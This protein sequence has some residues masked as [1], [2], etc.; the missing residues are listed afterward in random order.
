[1]MSLQDG[2]EAQVSDKDQTIFLDGRTELLGS[3]Q[4]WKSFAG[5]RDLYASIEASTLILPATS[6]RQQLF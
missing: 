2:E 4:N 6:C 3:D 5:L 1:M